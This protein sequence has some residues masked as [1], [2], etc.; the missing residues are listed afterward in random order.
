MMTVIVNS[1]H[2]RPRQFWAVKLG[3]ELI[4]H[5]AQTPAITVSQLAK[6]AGH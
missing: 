4:M 6:K 3:E 1:L 2:S 5:K